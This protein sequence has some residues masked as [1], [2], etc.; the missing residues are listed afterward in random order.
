MALEHAQSGEVVDVRPL[1]ATLADAKT[2]TLAK[3][4]A[5]ELLRLVV[6]AGKEIPTH[7]APGE[8]IVHCLEGRV[9]FTARDVINAHSFNKSEMV[10]AKDCSVFRLPTELFV[11]PADVFN[12]RE[13]VFESGDFL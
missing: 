1:G 8:I 7:A 3:T 9:T 13:S 4:D 10:L 2:T 11:D 12:L 6:P 5:F